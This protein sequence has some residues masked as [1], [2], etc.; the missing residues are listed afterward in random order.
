MC[1]MSRVCALSKIHLPKRSKT[2]MLNAE[3]NFEMYNLVFKPKH[4]RGRLNDH[5]T[6]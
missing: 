3:P 6:Q 1:I 4:E 2:E 5:S